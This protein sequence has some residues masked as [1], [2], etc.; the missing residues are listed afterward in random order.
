MNDAENSYCFQIDVKDPKFSLYEDA[1]IRYLISDMPVAVKA[2][3]TCVELENDGIYNCDEDGRIAVKVKSSC[4]S[5][6]TLTVTAG[7]VGRTFTINISAA[8]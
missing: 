4:T 3:D 6:T 7:V 2:A 5:V 1:T 8:K